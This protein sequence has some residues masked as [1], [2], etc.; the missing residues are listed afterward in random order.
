VVPIYRG[1][2]QTIRLALLVVKEV[3]RLALVS[4]FCR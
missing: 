1:A 3:R 2:Q 4:G